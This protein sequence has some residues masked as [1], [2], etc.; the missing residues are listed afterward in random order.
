MSPTQCSFPI[1]KLF[2]SQLLSVLGA[3]P[4]PPGQVYSSLCKTRELG[5]FVQLLLEGCF[6]LQ[7]F[8]N[9]LLVLS[10][11]FKVKLCC[12]DVA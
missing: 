3:P 1:I 2:C 4:H 10:T 5:Q 8:S 6:N 12:P 9:I 11:L 7:V